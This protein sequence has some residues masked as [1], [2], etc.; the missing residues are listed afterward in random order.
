MQCQTRVQQVIH[1]FDRGCAKVH[2]RL[3]EVILNENVPSHQPYVLK[4]AYGRDDLNFA[5]SRS[6]CA[7]FHQRHCTKLAR[8]IFIEIRPTG[9]EA[10]F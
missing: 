10:V 8:E 7:N 6:S 9:F 4:G 3:L 2:F 1:R 5:R